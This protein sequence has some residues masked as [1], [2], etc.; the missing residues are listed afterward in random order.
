MDKARLEAFSDGVFSVAITLMAVELHPFDMTGVS[1][2]L[3]F[4]PKFLLFT[5]SF[6]TVAL[7]WVNHHQLCLHMRRVNL[8]ILWLNI[9]ALL[10]VTVIPLATVLLG[11]NFN[12]PLAIAFYN[13]TMFAVSSV[14]Y[15]LA[16]AVHGDLRQF[17]W[18]RYIG[19]TFYGLGVLAPFVSPVIWVAYIFTVIPRA[20]SFI[21]WSLTQGKKYQS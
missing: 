11:E 12:Q 20:L 21:P 19:V 3:P 6:I 16:V 14:F 4:L 1:A 2:L 13:L 18:Q 15:R 10:F 5:F 8:N 7:W 9:F 17:G